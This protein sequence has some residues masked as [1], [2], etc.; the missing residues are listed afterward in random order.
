MSHRL[1][2]KTTGF[3]HRRRH[4]TKPNLKGFG[5][6]FRAGVSAETMKTTTINTR[7]VVTAIS[8]SSQRGFLSYQ[9][10]P[11][12]AYAAVSRVPA[13]AVQKGQSFR[14]ILERELGGDQSATADSK[15]TQLLTGFWGVA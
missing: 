15:T 7:S 1:K 10:K 13:A 8:G 9:R 11:A 6:G 4:S 14:D 2:G 5:P 12:P 3:S